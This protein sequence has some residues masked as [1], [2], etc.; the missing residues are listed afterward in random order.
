MPP[1]DA[2]NNMFDEWR[3]TALAE[4]TTAQRSV[5]VPGRPEEFAGADA[6]RYTSSFDDPRKPADDIAVLE[7]RGLYAHSEVEVTGD[8]LD[9]EGAVEHD[10]YFRPLRIPFLPFEDNELTV[11]CHAP[12][13]RFGGLHDTSMVPDE[14]AV[15]GIWWGASVESRPLP[16]IDNIDVRP[17]ITAEGTKL[18]LRTTVVADEILDD[19]ITYSVKPAGDTTSRGM[20]QRASVETDG[21]GKTVLEHTVDVHDPELWWPRELGQQNRYT[22]RGKLGDSEYSVTT[23]LCDIDFDDGQFE[24]NGETLSIRG[25]NVLTD[26]VSDVER[27]LSCNVNLVRGHA[28]VLPDQFYERCN[29]AGVLVWQDLPLTG[30]G[31]FDVERGRELATTL[32][33]QYGRHP[34]L[35]A[36]T[37]HD[38]PVEVFSA[39]I[40]SGF[41]DR[42]RL[43]YRAWRSGY[44]SEPAQ[45]VAETLPDHRPRFPAI[46]GPGT[47]TAVGSYYPGWSYGEAGSIDS[48]L[49]RYP[50]SVVAEFGAG[51]FGDENASGSETIAGFD[52]EKH[53]RHVSNGL[54]SSQAYQADLLRTVTEY[55][56][57]ERYGAIVYALRDTDAAGFGIYTQDGEKK[58]AAETLSRAFSPVQAFLTSPEEAESEIV[59]L[60]DTRRGFT[61]ELDWSAGEN[62]GTIELTVGDQGRWTGGPIQIGTDASEITLDLSVNEHTVTNRYRR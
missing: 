37:V 4:D 1:A 57:R 33:R 59:V 46:G 24:I 32:G 48:L 11:T 44:D 2:Q 25:V 61:A 30:P 22:V 40:G 26:D 55:L 7:F 56:R 15:P 35:A 47:G 6:V 54:D 45:S 39:G 52:R 62:G 21:P 50:V 14:M 13:D 23:G 19:R 38:D 51:A 27:A 36:C 58:E 28:Q 42:L 49:E 16:Y 9:G 34:S 60:N 10:A 53:D 31:E 5:S 18:H 17:E 3:A 41:F 12:R 20:M 29:E 8:R 43:R